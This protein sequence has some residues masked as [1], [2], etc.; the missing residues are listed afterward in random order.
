MASLDF[1][2]DLVAA[3]S[4]SSISAGSTGLGFLAVFFLLATLDALIAT[5]IAGR[6]AVSTRLLKDLSDS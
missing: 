1:L 6:R 2:P 4:A 3:S 5:S